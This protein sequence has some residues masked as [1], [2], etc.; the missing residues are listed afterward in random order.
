MFFDLIE[1]RRSI[2]KFKPAPV[3]R[4]KVDKLI[5]T[6]LRSPS[7][8]GFNPWQFVVV[9]QPEIIEQLSTAKPHGSAF[10]KNATLETEKV[11]INSYG[12]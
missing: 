10:L 3:E 12:N 7:T 5:E 6:A 2:R 1:K 11:H 8:L 4:E 9:D